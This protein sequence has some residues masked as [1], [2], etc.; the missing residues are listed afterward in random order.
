[1]ENIHGWCN[2]KRNMYNP[3]NNSSQLTI[4]EKML[5]SFIDIT[6]TTLY[7]SL[8]LSKKRC[9]IVSSKLQKQHFILPFHCRRARLSL[10]RTIPFC[11]YQM[12]T[13]IFKGSF[14]FQTIL[15]YGTAKGATKALYIDRT[16]DRTVNWLF[17]FGIHKKVSF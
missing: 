13:L 12:K 14:N 4:E 8:S 5:D 3:P 7:T 1:M 16:I 10:V 2:I 15:L 6:E 17:C 9:W 11:K